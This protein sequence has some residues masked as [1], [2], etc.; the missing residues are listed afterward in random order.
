MQKIDL[1]KAIHAFEQILNG[2][3]QAQNT[4]YN[5]ITGRENGY[6]PGLVKRQKNE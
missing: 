6:L 3:P 4:N 1:E 5:A 2:V